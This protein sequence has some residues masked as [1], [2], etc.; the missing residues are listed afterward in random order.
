MSPDRPATEAVL[1]RI[2]IGTDIVEA[3][4]LTA[5]L[6]D[7]P[8]L[9]SRIFTAREL[10]YCDGRRRGAEHLAARFAAKEAVLKALG[11][12]LG[13]LMR[14]ADVEVVNRLDGRPEIR[15]HGRVA[16]VA[17]RRGA[18]RIDV[19]LSH[20]AGLAIACALLV[21]QPEGRPVGAAP[22]HPPQ[23]RS[24]VPAAGSAPVPVAASGARR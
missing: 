6:V 13:P 22:A 17:R 9:A 16:A 21:C 2:L 24:A 23:R 10:S 20:T 4:R 15:L 5:L 18:E 7:Q 1:P 14:W 11:T 19:S 3:A 8:G 12:G